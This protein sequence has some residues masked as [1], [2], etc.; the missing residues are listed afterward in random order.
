LANLEWGIRAQSSL[1][2]KVPSIIEEDE[3][4]VVAKEETFPLLSLSIFWRRRRAGN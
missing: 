3:E 1:E 2:L 4:D